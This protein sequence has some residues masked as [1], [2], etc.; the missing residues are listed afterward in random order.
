MR[1]V[2]SKFHHLSASSA[3]AARLAQSV[4]HQTFSLRVMGSSPISGDFIYT[5][6]FF[7]PGHVV[8]FSGAF[9]VK[10]IGTHYTIW[11]AVRG[12]PLK[13]SFQTMVVG[14]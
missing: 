9:P 11:S 3:G 10:L 1:H 13:G 5:L 2:T 7:F 6:F 12:S 8:S 14:I 4:E